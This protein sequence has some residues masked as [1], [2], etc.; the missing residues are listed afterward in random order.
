[1][2]NPDDWYS[3]SC[4][5]LAYAGLGNKTDAVITGNTAVKLAS[6][7]NLVKIDM[8]INLAKIYAMSGDKAEAIRLVKYLISNPSWFSLNLLKVD[9]AWGK[10]SDEPEI[11]SLTL[12]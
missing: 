12:K 10:L 4:C 7:D 8:I 6:E 5:G 11:R 9:P 2:E 1:M 3:Y